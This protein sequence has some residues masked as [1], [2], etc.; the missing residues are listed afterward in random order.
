MDM[1]RRLGSLLAYGPTC[2]QACLIALACAS[3]ASAQRGPDH[4]PLRDHPVMVYHESWWE[5]AGTAGPQLTL[6][7][8]PPSVDIVALAFAKP[9]LVYPGGLDLR[10]TGLEYRTDGRVVRDAIAALHRRNPRVRVLLSVGG[11]AYTGWDRLDENAVARLAADLAVDGIDIDY[12]PPKPDCRAGPACTSDPA[13]RGYVRRLRQILPR[14][15]LLSVSAWS[16]GAYGQGRWTD[17]VP[18]SPW[19]GS[20]VNLLRSPEA[21]LLDLVSI[22]AYGAG[23]RYRPTEAFAAYRSLWPGPL[24]LGIEGPPATGGGPPA[25]ASMAR[26]VAIQVSTDPRG[27]LMVYSWLGRPADAAPPAGLPLAASA[28]RTFR[29]NC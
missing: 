22:A 28:C 12:E 25:T 20:M 15:A 16:V 24:L 13:W 8:I 17:A 18:P 3:A 23:P 5:R 27:G 26:Q 29:R 10:A 19:F 4:G 11:A 21:G 9:D 2:I 1:L 6:A 14:P 7:Q